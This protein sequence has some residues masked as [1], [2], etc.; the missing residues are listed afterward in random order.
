MSAV[1]T[2]CRLALQSEISDSEDPLINCVCLC[3]W[4][5][6]SPG[7]H[8]TGTAVCRSDLPSPQCQVSSRLSWQ[9]THHN[10]GLSLVVNQL[11]LLYLRLFVLFGWTSEV[12]YNETIVRLWLNIWVC[13]RPQLRRWHDC[14]SSIEI[15]QTSWLAYI[16][17]QVL[18]IDEIA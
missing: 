13:L 16:L 11:N 9:V 1:S 8:Q 5:P 17:G 15:L 6:L 4:M 2:N 18:L 3:P 7:L 14:I 10:F 12:L